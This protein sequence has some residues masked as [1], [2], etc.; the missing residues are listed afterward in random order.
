MLQKLSLCP[1]GCEVVFD[2]W[3]IFEG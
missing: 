3:G 1:R 2:W